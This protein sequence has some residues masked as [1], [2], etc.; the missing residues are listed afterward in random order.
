MLGRKDLAHERWT[1]EDCRA[2]RGEP[3][4]DVT[5]RVMFAPSVD[6]EME[7]VVRA[8]EMM[9]AKVSPTTEQMESLCWSLY[10][11]RDCHDC[12]RGTCE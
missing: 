3:R 8:H 10:R 6:G 7:R 5:H 2:V 9:H 1:V 12:R 11:F 4:T